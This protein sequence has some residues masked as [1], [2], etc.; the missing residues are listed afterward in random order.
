MAK[1]QLWYLSSIGKKVTVAVTGLILLGFVVIHLAGNLLI[2]LG[3]AAF[4]AYAEK[5]EYLGGIVWAARIILLLAVLLHIVV[6]IQLT[7]E[8]RNARPIAYE[9]KNSIRMNPASK[10]MIFSGLL[11]L[12]FIVYHLLHFTFGVTHPE[13]AQLK[14]AQGEHD[15]YS[16]VVLSF[17]Q[18]PLAVAYGIAMMLLAL[19]LSHG[20]SSAFQTLGLNNESKMKCV[21]CVG[22]IFAFFIFLGYTSIPVSIFLGIVG[23]TP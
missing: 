19:H 15:V 23:S 12:A 20:T 2:F 1:A 9:R 5:L 4:N 17:K 13:L 18:A 3:P 14:D 11:V 10:T 7:A 16:M 6:S 8:N 21:A 22:K